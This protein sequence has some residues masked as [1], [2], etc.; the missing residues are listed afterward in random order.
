MVVRLTSAAEE[1]ARSAAAEKAVRPLA[2]ADTPAPPVQPAVE[3]EPPEAEPA[4]PSPA[5]TEPEMH[6]AVEATPSPVAL[7]EDQ[8]EDEAR[9]TSAEG[10]PLHRWVQVATHSDDESAVADWAHAL[11]SNRLNTKRD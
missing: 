5:A 10:L 2:A 8:N 7:A 3:D 11:L 1:T 6:E 4:A 9:K